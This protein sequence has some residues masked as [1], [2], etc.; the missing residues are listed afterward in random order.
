MKQGK[1]NGDCHV[2][3]CNKEGDT[4]TGVMDFLGFM[5][6][7]A[8]DIQGVAALYGFYLANTIRDLGNSPRWAA[9]LNKWSTTLAEQYIEIGYRTTAGDGLIIRTW[10]TGATASGK[11]PVIIA[12]KV[13]GKTETWLDAQGDLKNAGAVE[14]AAG[15]AAEALKRL[16]QLGVNYGKSHGAEEL[17][18]TYSRRILQNEVERTQ[19]ALQRLVAAAALVPHI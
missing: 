5:F 10:V 12:S 4:P 18:Q 2:V 13:T 6:E 16:Q 15:S 7:D 1:F 8:N 17:I 19:A 14:I 9:F 11:W 3:F